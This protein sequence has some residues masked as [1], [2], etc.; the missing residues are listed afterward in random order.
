MRVFITG[1][2]GFVGKH[3]VNQI[4]DGGH[5]ILASALDKDASEIDRKNVQW[6]YGDLGDIE[7]LKPAIGSFNPEVVMHLAWE[8]IPDYSEFIS[9]KNLINSIQFLD[10]IVEKTCCKKII[11]AGSCLEYGKK[12]GECKESD[13]VK[14]NS[15][16]S[17]AK[18]S[19]CQYLSLK[20]N[21]RK[22]DLIWFRIFYVYGPYQRN[23][24]LIPTLVQTLKDNGIPDI[25]SVFN[26]NDFIYVEDVARAFRLALEME[27]ESGIYNLGYGS[28]ITVYDVCETVE[29]LMHGSTDISK[30]ILNNSSKKENIN[31]WANSVKTA[32]ALNWTS[33]IALKQGIENYIKSV[34]RS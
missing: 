13:P 17:W 9:R 2:S 20:C 12:N 34:Y 33:N 21:Q 27:V 15:F 24:S 32:K 7:P 26:K 8:G 18:H 10:F 14:I 3:V 22:A 11:V 28:P 23:G 30:R 16:F 29:N 5:T 31:F 4:Q 6:L 1:A 19:L 25:S